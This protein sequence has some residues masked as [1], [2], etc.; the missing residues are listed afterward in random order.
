MSRMSLHSNAAARTQRDHWL[1]PDR[2]G[3]RERQ[4]PRLCQRGQYENALHPREALA[5]A[6]SRSAAE[7]KICELRPRGVGRESSRIEAI[8]I[9]PVARIAMH[10]ILR[11]DGDGAAR[12][13]V[14]A[15][16]V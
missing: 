9:R 2:Q 7:R 8:R 10:H 13:R 11:H 15:D 16:L 12:N 14:A 4:A 3:L 1:G 6:D 5:D